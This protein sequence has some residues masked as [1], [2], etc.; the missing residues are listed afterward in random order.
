MMLIE[1]VV[2]VVH[3]T[4]PPPSQQSSGKFTEIDSSQLIPMSSIGTALSA[5][6]IVVL[7]CENSFNS[8]KS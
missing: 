3:W 7:R 2:L 4:M 6:H 8:T 5:W 1:S